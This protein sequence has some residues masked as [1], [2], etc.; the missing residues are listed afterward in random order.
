MASVSQV[1]SAVHIRAN[2]VPLN[3]VPTS[4]LGLRCVSRAAD[5]NG[6]PTVGRDDVAGLRRSAADKQFQPPRLIPP[7]A[8]PK[9]T[10]P[11]TSTPMKFPCTVVPGVSKAQ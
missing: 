2:V 8:F 11:V 4:W 1:Q 10:V 3:G 9:A 6:I 7:S 5:G